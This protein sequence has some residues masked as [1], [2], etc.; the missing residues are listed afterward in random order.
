MDE[1]GFDK[2]T[3]LK[4]TAYAVGSI[5]VGSENVQIDTSLKSASTLAQTLKPI[6]KKKPRRLIKVVKFFSY[7]KNNSNIRGV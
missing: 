1:N 7:A 4:A 5:N 3:L 6:W 2:S